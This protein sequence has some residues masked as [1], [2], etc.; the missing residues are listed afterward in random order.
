MYITFI[1]SG[2][3]AAGN[4]YIIINP[5]EQDIFVIGVGPY[6][7]CIAGVG[8]HACLLYY[9]EIAGAVLFYG[10]DGGE[11]EDGKEGEEE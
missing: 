9:C 1:L 10:E 11:E 3:I 7:H 2:K 6:Q 8:S 5:F 4:G